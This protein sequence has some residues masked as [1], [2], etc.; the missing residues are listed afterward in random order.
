MSQGHKPGEQL[1]GGVG[2]VAAAVAYTHTDSIRQVG[3]FDPRNG[4]A[5][6]VVKQECAID[7][8]VLWNFDIKYPGWEFE[9]AREV[10]HL[11]NFQKSLHC[12]IVAGKS[13]NL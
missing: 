4:Q 6:T 12:S 7:K 8:A 10:N 13:D 1:T 9:V 2:A 5:W 11:L 3:D